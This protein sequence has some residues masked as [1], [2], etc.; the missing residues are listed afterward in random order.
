MYLAQGS[1]PSSVFYEEKVESTPGSPGFIYLRNPDT[2]PD[3][4]AVVFCNVQG[5]TSA[6]KV[7]LSCESGGIVH[8]HFKYLVK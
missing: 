2:S 8:L 7:V 5:G 6:T 1:Y 4:E 3:A